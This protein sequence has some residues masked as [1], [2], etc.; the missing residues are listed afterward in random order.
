MEELS[1]KPLSRDQD[2]AL[3]ALTERW[4]LTELFQCQTIHV[5]AH[6]D[7]FETAVARFTVGDCGLAYP[8][9]NHLLFCIPWEANANQLSPPSSPE[10]LDG[11]SELVAMAQQLQSDCGYGKRFN[12]IMMNLFQPS[13]ATAWHEDEEV[14]KAMAIRWHQDPFL[15]QGSPIAVCHLGEADD[16]WTVGCRPLPD[17]TSSTSVTPVTLHPLPSSCTYIMPP[18]FNDAHQHAVIA[19][20]QRR[21]SYVFRDLKVSRYTS[22]NQLMRE[23]LSCQRDINVRHDTARVDSDAREHALMLLQCA[24]CH[25]MAG[26]MAHTEEYRKQRPCWQ[27]WLR[28]LDKEACTLASQVYGSVARSDLRSSRR[29]DRWLQARKQLKDST[30]A[31]MAKVFELPRHVIIVE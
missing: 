25:W 24:E 10:L 20:E 3:R 30:S 17:D 12:M 29:K 16:E 9:F 22:L 28:A 4:L 15:T 27:R 14:G 21:F 1:I 8:Y 26:F 2:S 18:T 7:A 19:G 23:I 13:S 11:S 5:R 6:Q 31:F